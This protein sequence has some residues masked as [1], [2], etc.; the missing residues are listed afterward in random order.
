MS[1]H[2]ESSCPSRSDL[3]AASR[4]PSPWRPRTAW[5]QTSLR[6][7]NHEIK[8][9]IRQLLQIGRIAFLKRAVGEAMLRGALTPSLHQV[10]RDIDAQHVRS[11]FRRGQRRRAIATSEVEHP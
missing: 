10:A 1:D 11:E 8:R 5:A 6:N 7:T 4:A 3:P 9:L 2:S